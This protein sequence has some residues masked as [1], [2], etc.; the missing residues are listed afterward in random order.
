M[1]NNYRW[2][3]EFQLSKKD[4]R[5]NKKGKI[6]EQTIHEKDTQITNTRNI[7]FSTS[8]FIRGMKMKTAKFSPTRMDSTKKPETTKCLWGCGTTGAL[9]PWGW[10]DEMVQQ[11]SEIICQFFFNKAQHTPTLW[12]LIP[13]LSIYPK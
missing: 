2:S 10:Q 8:L 3:K 6:H 11:L 4:E 13:L 5:S 9:I 12:P 7:K 1:T